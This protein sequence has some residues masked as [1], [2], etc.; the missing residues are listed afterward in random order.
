MAVGGTGV[1]L[2]AVLISL[3]PGR[4]VVWVLMGSGALVTVVLTFLIP[5]IRKPRIGALQDS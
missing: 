1:V 5:V 3:Y 2:G 4:T